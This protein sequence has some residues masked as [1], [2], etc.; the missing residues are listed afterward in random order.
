[1]ATTATLSFVC[2]FVI[3]FTGMKSSLNLI[4]QQD[5]LAVK[6]TW[7]VHIYFY[8]YHI[9]IF[10]HYLTLSEKTCPAVRQSESP[11]GLLLR[12]K[13]FSFSISDSSAEGISAL[14]SQFICFRPAWM[15]DSYALA[16]LYHVLTGCLIQAK[17][18]FG[19]KV[20]QDLVP[21]LILNQLMS[22][23]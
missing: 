15:M 23:L 22:V 9:N 7:T 18:F 21:V 19:R 3:I 12:L 5:L 2:V 4:I 17:C 10:H 8:R 20:F 6:R 11:S 1:M 13:M 14:Y 16:G